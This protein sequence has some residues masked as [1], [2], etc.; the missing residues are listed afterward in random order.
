MIIKNQWSN[1]I[2]MKIAIVGPVYPYKGGISHYTSLLWKALSKKYDVKLFSFKRQYPNFL[3]PGKEQKDFE[4]D[5]FK[6]VDT[7]Y[8]IDSI[9]PFNWFFSFIKI[10]RF[11][12][13]LLIF[14][15][16]NPF[17]SFA[18]LTIAYLMRIFTKTKVLFLC[19]NVLPHDKYPFSKLLT[20]ITLYSGNYFIVHSGEDEKKLVNLINKCRYLKSILPTFNVFRF[21]DLS[22]DVAKTL[23]NIEMNTKV[24]LFFGFVREY[25]GLMYLIEALPQ[26]VQR[27]PDIKLLIVGD[28]YTD[29]EIYIQKIND[30]G[31]HNY[32]L[33]FD[34]YI[35]D[36]EVGRYFSACD[37]VVLPYTSATQSGIVQIAYGFNKPVIVTDVGGLPEVVKNGETGYIVKSKDIDDISKAVINFYEQ[38]KEYYFVKNIISEQD[39][40][41]WD[42]LVNNIEQLCGLK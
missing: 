17:F 16:W 3:Y 7:N 29:K 18:F 6:I 23:L 39:I 2:I 25:K 19:H 12:P 13:D 34:S 11:K 24:V 5:Q 32:I 15:W 1:R 27:I 28:F 30:L 36:K 26:I 31:L 33:I 37:I 20:R 35:P 9:N 8:L 42:K 21:E 10:N 40:Y 38:E 22:K 14:Q 4:N 41:S